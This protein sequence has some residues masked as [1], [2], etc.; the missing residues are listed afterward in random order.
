MRV[1]EARGRLGAVRCKGAGLSR[2]AGSCLGLGTSCTLTMAASGSVWR[3]DGMSAWNLRPRDA[4]FTPPTLLKHTSNHVN[5]WLNFNFEAIGLCHFILS[6]FKLKELCELHIMKLLFAILT[7]K[8]PIYLYERFIFMSSI[9][10]RNTGRGS[11]S[12]AIPYHDIIPLLYT[13][14]SSVSMQPAYEIPPWPDK[15]LWQMGSVC[16]RV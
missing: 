16:G 5:F 4:L 2:R 12:L 13:T 8:S 15:S 7:I 14:N 6:V 3:P 11:S 10:A 9:T 1:R